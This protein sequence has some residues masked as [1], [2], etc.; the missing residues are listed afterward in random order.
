MPAAPPLLLVTR[1][2]R[3]AQAWVLALGALGLQAQA[4]PL[5]AIGPAPDPAALARRRAEVAD[6]AAVMFVSANAAR[7]FFSSPPVVAWPTGTRA[8]ATGPGTAAALLEA[9]VPASQLDVP[10]ESG[11]QFDSEALWSQVK[12]QPLAGRRVLIVRGADARGE[13]AGRAWLA[14]QLEAAGAQVD[15]VAAYCRTLPAWGE[16]EHALLAQA[17]SAP[18]TACWHF[19]SS[20]AV[21]NLARLAP[22]GGW[23]GAQALCTHARIA[24]AARDAGFGRVVTLAP[25]PEAVAA[26]LQSQP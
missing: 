10:P 22:G 24:Q 20:E 11:G 6:D 13:V 3:E 19:S 17:R 5:I 26:F 12:G 1:P 9:G 16:A 14:Q 8:W 23:S 25:G 21:A 2:D 7:G 18:A 4:L 15:E